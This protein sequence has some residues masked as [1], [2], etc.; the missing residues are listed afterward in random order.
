[1]TQALAL[2]GMEDK[3]DQ[4]YPT[5]SGGEQQKVHLARVLAQ[6]WRDAG[7]AS[8]NDARRYLFLD[9]PI[10]GLD[11]HYQLHILN[12]VRGLLA[13]D[14]TIV[15]VLHDLNV[16]FE[17]GDHF[18]VLERGRV[19]AE[20]ANSKSIST[21]VL[22]RVFRVKARRA[23]RAPAPAR[24]SGTSSSER[25]GDASPSHWNICYNMYIYVHA[26]PPSG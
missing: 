10:S 25:M 8:A 3:R 4:A 2:V 1:M 18:V 16:A 12:V 5:L 17:Y 22:E 21:S 13:P 20:G 24:S 23:R 11:V 7:S 19:A 15:A 26:N 6:L 9:E 14:L